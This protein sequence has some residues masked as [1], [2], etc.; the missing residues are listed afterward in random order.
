MDIDVSTEEPPAQATPEAP[1]LPEA[2][3]ATPPPGAPQST[4]SSSGNG[5]ALVIIG[6]I[7]AIALGALVI[8]QAGLW[9]AP[10]P[11]ADAYTVQPYTPPSQLISVGDHVL[12]H[13]RPDAASPGV[14]MFGPGVALTITG[15][16]SRGFADDWYAITWN[17]QTA[18]IRQQDAAPGAATAPPP[19]APHVIVPPREPPKPDDVETG[20][21][22]LTQ[23]APPPASGPFELSGVRWVSRPGRRDYERAFPQRALNSGQ[24]GRVTLDCTASGSGALDCSIGNELPRGY[25]FGSAALNLSR[26][27]RIA[28]TTN[29]G[30]SVA[31]GHISVPVEFRAS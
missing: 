31:G 1:P 17:N 29:D 10:H 11:R 7:A 13:A 3:P 2:A 8:S 20:V 21:P 5:P 18:F 15:R 16:V 6:A 24:S 22:D 23:T 30:R 19:T 25:G 9:F 28:P 26:Q 4:F 12:A 27:F 14:V